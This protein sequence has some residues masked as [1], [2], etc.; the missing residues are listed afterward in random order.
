MVEWQVNEE[1]AWFKLWPK[2]CPRN[3]NFKEMTCGDFFEIQRQKYPEEIFMWFLKSQMTYDEVG[4]Y[5]DILAT[6][7]FHLGLHQG[8]VIALLMPN[9]PQYVIS[10]LACVKVG[11]IVTAIN[12]TL[13]E[14][15]ILHHLKVTN[16]TA[17]I[18]IDALWEE[19]VRPVIYK[20]DVELLISS[21]IADLVGKKRK[22][23]KT[24]GK[25]PKVD[26]DF[27]RALKLMDLLRAEE[28]L[29]DVDI[30][31]RRDTAVYA[32]TGGT[33]GTPKVIALTHYNIVS[34]AQQ[35]M[36]WLGGENPGLGFIGAIPLFHPFGMIGVMNTCI[37]LGGWMMLFPAPP[38]TGELLAEVDE[39]YAPTGFVFIGPELFF[40]RI[41]DSPV[42]DDFPNVWNQLKLCISAANPVQSSIKQLFENQ[43]GGKLVQSYGLTEASSIVSAGNLIEKSPLDCLGIPLPG[44][45]WA[46]FNPEDFRNG[47]IAD[48]LPGSKFGQ[49]NVG[50]LCVCGP[51]VMKEYTR[52]I[53][54]TKMV[55]R[56][57]GGK[58]WLLTG[59]LG[60]MNE[61][62]TVVLVE[63]KEIDK[64]G[65][66][67]A[68]FL[69]DIETM[70]MKHKAVLD[71]AVFG[72]PPEG[73]K[74]GMIMKIWITLKPMF[75][76]KISPK[77]LKTW[78]EKS[79][80]NW[81]VMPEIEFVGKLPKAVLG[82]VQKRT[83]QIGGISKAKLDK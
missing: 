2:N 78:I 60:F 69:I 1:K 68:A 22:V 70:V 42:L 7:L 16:P 26:V 66:G 41:V 8:D 25:I 44:T 21:N 29:P 53:D 12:P 31:P 5:V 46:I 61:D 62:G 18:S 37:A 23:Q 40:K 48:G 45:D 30:N 15:E 49:E 35:L 75:V 6:A 36:Y 10:Y 67:E 47:P 17:I 72:F 20:T 34:N 3:V 24:Y 43:L 11:I 9:C 58:M 4:H 74:R 76:G 65:A 80:F 28:Y 27:P 82:K 50:E 38:E 19:T 63:R 54:D 32:I 79:F 59:D 55:L 64:K 81:R 56:S 14:N 51:Q 77:Q 33:M 57:Y 71:A 39:I 52:N 73:Q 83:A 13:R